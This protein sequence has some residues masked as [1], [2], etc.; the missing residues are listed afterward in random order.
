MVLLRFFQSQFAKKDKRC[1]IRP[2]SSNL[3]SYLTFKVQK[4]KVIIAKFAFRVLQQI[5]FFI[6]NILKSTTMPYNR[7]CF[8]RLVSCH[9]IIKL[10]FNTLCYSLAKLKVQCAHQ[11]SLKKH[12]YYWKEYQLP[13]IYCLSRYNKEKIRIFIKAQVPN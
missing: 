11:L 3:K 12:V 10:E 13:C 8:C 4:Q 6:T 1:F 2:F 7:N 5:Y 9:R